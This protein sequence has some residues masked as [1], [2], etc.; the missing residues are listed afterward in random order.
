[1]EE[2]VSQ[3]QAKK[4]SSYEA[5][6][7]INRIAGSRNPPRPAYTEVTDGKG[8]NPYRFMCV[9]R[10]P[11]LDRSRGKIEWGLNCTGCRDKFHDRTDGKLDWR[12]LYTTRGYVE[13]VGQCRKSIE[14]LE[15][16]V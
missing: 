6:V 11:W 3:L 5:K 4:I 14:I 15:S 9:V 7:Q 13:H 16:I 2:Y 8:G 1:M 12:W 10:F